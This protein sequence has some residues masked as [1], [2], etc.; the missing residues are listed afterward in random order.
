MQKKI[1][2]TAL[3]LGLFLTGYLSVKGTSGASAAKLAGV[4]QHNVDVPI[5]GL[6]GN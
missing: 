2:W 6:S 3:F 5:G 1:I 4:P